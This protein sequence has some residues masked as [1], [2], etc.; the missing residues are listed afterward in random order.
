MSLLVRQMRSW[1]IS[2]LVSCYGTRR[3]ETNTVRDP[4][5][6]N[7]PES[8]AGGVQGSTRLEKVV[9]IPVGCGDGHEIPFHHAAWLLRRRFALGMRIGGIEY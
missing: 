7:P 9:C 3:G 8:C 4:M 2:G 6:L 5:E 1:I